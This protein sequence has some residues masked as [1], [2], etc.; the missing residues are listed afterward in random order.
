MEDK[1][2]VIT[3][4]ASQ[5]LLQNAETLVCED[6]AGYIIKVF[7]HNKHLFLI[8]WVDGS[9]DICIEGKYR[10]NDKKYNKVIQH[11]IK[12]GWI[13]EDDEIFSE[14]PPNLFKEDDYV[15]I[16]SSLEDVVAHIAA[17]DVLVHEE[18]NTECQL[19]T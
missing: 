3:Y 19:D 10:F 16:E 6:F 7:R 1:K 4:D 9:I 8:I 11:L 13:E 17:G 15:Y 2:Y 14:F 18:D 5:W 12:I